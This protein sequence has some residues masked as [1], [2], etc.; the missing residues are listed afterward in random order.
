MATNN[1]QFEKDLL[2]WADDIADKFKDVLIKK[3]LKASG[4]LINSIKTR[5]T[6]NGLGVEIYLDDSVDKYYDV[7]DKGRRPNKKAPPISAIKAWAS[8]K[9]ITDPGAPYAI[10]KSIAKKGIIKRFDYKGAQYSKDW[11]NIF[12]Q[13]ISKLLPKLEQDMIVKLDGLF[14]QIKVQIE[15]D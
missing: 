2:E 1:T 7:I 15:K 4:G 9:G 12:R 6:P 14:N 3:N 13:N 10:Q 5:L 11:T 8:I